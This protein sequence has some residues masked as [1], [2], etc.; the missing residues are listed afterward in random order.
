MNKKTLLSLI[1]TL[2]LAFIGVAKADVVEIGVGGTS[3]NSYLPTYEF[4]N[5]SLTQQIYTADEIGTAGIINSIAFYYVGT[6]TRNL[7]VYMVNTTVGSFSGNSDWIT[8]TA[9]DKV[10]SGWV[11]YTANAWN[12]F[13][14][15]T[16]FEY[17]G[18]SNLA[19]IVDDN[20]G[21]YVSSVGAYVFDASGMALRVYSDG[22]NYDPMAP[23]TGS[24][25][26]LNVKNQIQMDITPYHWTASESFQN[27]M[28]MIGVVQIDGVEQASATLELG[29]FCNGECRGTKFPVEDEGQWLYFMTIGGNVG[30][31]ITF[32][33]YDHVFQQELNLYC[34]NVIPFEIYGLI[35]IDEPYEVQ[36]A[37]IYSISASISPENAGAITGVGEYVIGTDATLTAIANEGYVFNS[38]TLDGEIV[39]TEPSYTFTV[40]SEMNLIANFDALYSVSATVSPENAGTI[41]GAGE[42]VSGTSATLIAMPNEG[43]AF[44]SWTL[45]GEVVST[46]PSYTFTVTEPVNLIANFDFVRTRQLAAGWNWWSTDLEITLDDLKTSLEDAYGSA[47]II[48]KSQNNG[49][50]TYNGNRWRGTLNELDVTQMYRIKVETDGEMTLTGVPVNPTE[51]P[52]TIFNGANWIAF[53]FNENMSVSAALAGF[54]AV[55]GDMIKSQENIAI[56]TRGEWRGALTT[57]EHGKGYVFLSSEMENRT[58]IF[59]ATK[60]K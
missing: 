12:T 2:L 51:Y 55:S 19:V 23:P 47:S 50:T 48:I 9:A 20:T 52:I 34:F 41:V 22:T 5:Y 38:W 45:D 8:V 24:G 14:L 1:M 26:V 27:S 37:S 53:P 6:A 33:L 25:A 15:D 35:G 31:E 42:Y 54:D 58:L 40:T 11:T 39:S 10:Y 18:T 29:A 57:F 36:F 28:F 43:Y 60:S 13:V 16:P 32:R 46:E 3:T 44:N 56:Y 4:Y 7:D 21:S 59:G 17:D 30:D 49:Q